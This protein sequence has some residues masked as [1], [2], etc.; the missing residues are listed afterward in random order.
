MSQT[1]LCPNGTSDP[2][3]LHFS[4]IFLYLPPFETTHRT[5]TTSGAP[6]L[7][8][9]RSPV[10]FV[11]EPT[12]ESSATRQQVKSPR[13]LLLK[14][15]L[16]FFFKSLWEKLFPEAGMWVLCRA[17]RASACWPV[18]CYKT[19]VGG[20]LVIPLSQMRELRLLGEEVRPQCCLPD[21]RVSWGTSARKMLFSTRGSLEVSSH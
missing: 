16:F 1:S 9:G 21:Y 15:K 12:F 17:Q 2:A 8:Q 14:H 18:A 19:R 11:F 6:C 7:M 3:P 4:L 20:A 5:N 13:L 10:L